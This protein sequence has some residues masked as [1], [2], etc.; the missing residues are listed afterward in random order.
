MKIVFYFHLQLIHLLILPLLAFIETMSFLLILV[1]MLKWKYIEFES[2]S[3]THLYIEFCL[4]RICFFR[5]N[6]L[7]I[8]FQCHHRLICYFK[9]IYA[10]VSSNQWV[11]SFNSLTALSIFKS[12]HPKISLFH[13]F[14][15]SLSNFSFSFS[16]YACAYFLIRSKDF[17]DCLINEMNSLCLDQQLFALNGF[18]P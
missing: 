12:I 16:A 14:S 11:Q 6:I 4:S 1:L 8:N 13:Y 9:I 2:P 10:V 7:S 15:F 5:L 17:H 18:G 3:L